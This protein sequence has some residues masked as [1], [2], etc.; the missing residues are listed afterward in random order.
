MFIV[1]FNLLLVCEAE[2]SGVL[3]TGHM[4]TEYTPNVQLHIMASHLS[5]F[6]LLREI[7]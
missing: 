3:F 4:Q 1:Y 5:L 7:S 6:C 2:Q